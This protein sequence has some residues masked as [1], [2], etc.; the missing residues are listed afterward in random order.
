MVEELEEQN[1]TLQ[2]QVYDLRNA[3]DKANDEKESVSETL[4]NRLNVSQQNWA[5]ER[6]DLLE[7]ARYAKEEHEATRQAMQDWEVIATEERS[8]RETLGDRVIDL[9]G[10]LFTRTAAYEKLVME[11]DRDT[12]AID[13]LQRALRDIQEGRHRQLSF[14]WSTTD[15]SHSSSKRT[16][17]SRRKYAGPDRSTHVKSAGA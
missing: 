5:K 9:E 11:K 17:R 16:A 7:E 8:V 15:N 6:D 3:L 2:E 14:Y 12:S 13:G 10:Q 1:K 4:R